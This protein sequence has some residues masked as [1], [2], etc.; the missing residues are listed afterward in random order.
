MRAQQRNPEL[1][2]TERCEGKPHPQHEQSERERR[3]ALAGRRRARR[4]GRRS[5][6][7]R[8]GDAALLGPL[9]TSSQG[10]VAPRTG[11]VMSVLLV[12]PLDTLQRGVT[13]SAAPAAAATAPRATAAAAAGAAE[14]V[15]PRC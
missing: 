14:R 9:V 15:T 4:G 7:R 3:T 12:D 11:A 2:R 8:A 13:R 10:T 5:G 6:G 1:Y